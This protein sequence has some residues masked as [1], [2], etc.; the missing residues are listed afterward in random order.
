LRRI[1]PWK[2]KPDFVADLKAEK[3]KIQKYVLALETENLKLQKQIAKLQAKN[4]TLKNRIKVLEA[5]Q[6]R[7]KPQFIIKGLHD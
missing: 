5:E 7:P 3:P 2:I 6:Y 4:V 1:T